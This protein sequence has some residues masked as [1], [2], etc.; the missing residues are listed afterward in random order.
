MHRP[1]S[2][3]LITQLD[4]TR[5][6]GDSYDTPLPVRLCFIEHQNDYRI[7]KS[8][9]ITKMHLMQ[10]IRNVIKNKEFMCL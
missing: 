6:I 1:K 2:I 4:S 8:M 10:I 5:P 3:V 7:S 9:E